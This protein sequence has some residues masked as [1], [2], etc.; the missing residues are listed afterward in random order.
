MTTSSKSRLPKILLT[1]P[2]IHAAD[3]FQLSLNL[4]FSSDSFVMQDYRWGRSLGFGTGHKVGQL[5]ASLYL[6]WKVRLLRR[7]LI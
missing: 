1:L 3:C 2:I 6:H 4:Q 7:F 5:I